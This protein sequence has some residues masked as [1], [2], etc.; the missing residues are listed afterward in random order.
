MASA[1]SALPDRLA[2]LG[3]KLKGTPPDAGAAGGGWP[4]PL[5]GLSAAPVG[6]PPPF[7]SGP[8]LACAQAAF[9]RSFAPTASTAQDPP[10]AM[11]LS[12][13]AEEDDSV[14]RREEGAP[15]EASVPQASHHE[16]RRHYPHARQ[17]P[18]ALASD[19]R[20][21]GRSRASSTAKQEL[22]PRVQGGSRAA[23]AGHAA[24]SVPPEGFHPGS[25]AGFPADADGTDKAEHGTDRGRGEA[26][27]PRELHTEALQRIAD[28]ARAQA[29]R[30]IAAASSAV[31]ETEDLA[32]Q[33]IA[34]RDAMIDLL[35]R[36]VE[37]LVTEGR[38]EPLPSTGR[39]PDHQHRQAQPANGPVH[40]AEP[41]LPKGPA[42]GEQLA[43]DMLAVECAAALAA[44]DIARLLAMLTT[45]L[46]AAE[47]AAA[48]WR[49]RCALAES[50]L[51]TAD[52]AAATAAGAEDHTSPRRGPRD[53]APSPAASWP[54]PATSDWGAVPS[55][56][57]LR[58]AAERA[59]SEQ[60]LK[61]SRAAD[62]ARLHDALARAP[63]PPQDPAR[64]GSRGRQQATADSESADVWP[65][66]LRSRDVAPTP[67]AGAIGLGL[68]RSA[69]ESWRGNARDPGMV[70]WR[71]PPASRS[72]RRRE[73]APGPLLESNLSA[74]ALLVDEFES[75]A[76]A[77]ADDAEATGGSV[78]SSIVEAMAAFVEARAAAEADLTAAE[79]V[80]RGGA[81]PVHDA[82]RLAGRVAERRRGLAAR[83]AEL[84]REVAGAVAAPEWVGAPH[85]PMAFVA[86]LP[87]ASA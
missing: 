28:A 30:A 57:E 51:R 44:D 32:V 15:A 52:G 17:S 45:R 55:V 39:P 20:L 72:T 73:R 83:M 78:P 23:C 85:P 9:M 38:R 11:T 58:A 49:E 1:F 31:R 61:L 86:G 50:K 84:R 80:L 8:G 34:A 19:R 46:E 71:A 25:P 63:S 43:A 64:G 87:S 77:I 3:A 75:L 36:Q 59:A 66:A 65:P 24:P 67:G 5:A 53:A 56:V 70:G 33:E 6:E 40:P 18:Y 48:H 10:S 76:R 47:A 35:S 62:A 81:A 12:T 29:D 82:T 22:G 14:R 26:N 60:A 74:V 68:Q 42:G 2:E 69:A 37:R 27:G 21:C 41:G 7:S 13:V 54:A 4:I 16:L 79:T